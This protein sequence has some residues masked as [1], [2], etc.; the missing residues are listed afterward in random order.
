MKMRIINRVLIALCLIAGGIVLWILYLYNYIPHRQYHD[1]D[2]QI[3]FQDAQN[4]ENHNG[5]DDF[6][7]I[8]AGAKQEVLRNPT[9]RSAYY[10]GGYPPPEEGVCT[11]VIWRSLAAAGYDFKA[12]IDADI[13]ACAECYP[14]TDGKPDPNIDFRRVPNVHVFLSRHT[15]S[16]TT[17]IYAIDE[18]QAGD[19]VVFSDRHIAIVSDLR[20]YRG[21]PF[22]IH[23]AGLYKMEEDCLWREAFL[24]GVSGHYR[25]IYH[26]KPNEY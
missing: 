10:E 17:D 4:D 15:Q 23:N 14:R 1:E 12:M 18:W 2:F 19:I 8:L 16:R 9:Y 25:F 3:V 6:H 26:E 24:K 13:A 5:I 21:I 22:L 11:D 7:D 20:N